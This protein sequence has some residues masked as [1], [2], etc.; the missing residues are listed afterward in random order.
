MT[1]TRRPCGA[2]ATAGCT[3]G[4]R[5]GDRGPVRA[6][7]AGQHRRGR[8][9]RAQRRRQAGQRRRRHGG[10][11]EN[12]ECR[13]GARGRPGLRR[14]QQPPHSL[15]ERERGTTWSIHEHGVQSTHDTGRTP[16]H[17]GAYVI[18]SGT[19]TS[20]FHGFAAALCFGPSSTVP[21]AG[22]SWHVGSS[23]HTHAHTH[24]CTSGWEHTHRHTQTRWHAASVVQYHDKQITKTNRGI[25]LAGGQ[26]ARAVRA[27]TARGSRSG[28]RRRYGAAATSAPSARSSA[29]SAA[30]SGSAA[31]ACS[32]PACVAAAS[33][34][35]VPDSVVKPLRAGALG[36][37]R[38]RLTCPAL[39][40]LINEAA[41]RAASKQPGP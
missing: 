37:R 3:C 4:A 30:A 11:G 23:A 34:P 24:T 2:R 26:R 9:A 13:A 1:S 10:V 18:D 7:Q 22:Q 27:C 29:A 21:F 5:G 41:A 36:P 15:R 35:S 12:V 28:G 33:W 39:A 31:S 20:S 16:A 14:R 17:G 25:G 38:E 6:A 40:C 8:R 32:R 19:R